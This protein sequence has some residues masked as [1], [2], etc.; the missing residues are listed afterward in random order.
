MALK[1]IAYSSVMKKCGGKTAN[2]SLAAPTGH[3]IGNI[4]SKLL[5]LTSLVVITLHPEHIIGFYCTFAVHCG[6]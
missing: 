3:L 4:S 5:A 6:M 2:K 1:S